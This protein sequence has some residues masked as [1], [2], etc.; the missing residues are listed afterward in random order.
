M[1]EG[2]IYSPPAIAIKEFR[3]P[4]VA[5]A[6]E[7]VYTAIRIL[8]PDADVHVAVDETLA[9]G[10]SGTMEVPLPPGRMC[11]Q[12]YGLEWGDPEVKLRWRIDVD[13]PAHEAAALHSVP[14]VPTWFEY[15]KF[16]EKREKLFLYRENT[17]TV[18]PRTYH[19][20]IYAVQPTPAQWAAWKPVISDFAQK[21]LAPR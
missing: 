5:V 12:R 8:H 9:P 6:L 19:L 3:A 7:Q 1:L 13:D 15:A 17:D 14:P 2:D 18:N 10:Y 20:S 4:V 21:V 16:W 11:V